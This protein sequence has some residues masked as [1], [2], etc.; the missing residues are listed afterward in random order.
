MAQVFKESV[1]RS[2]GADCTEVVIQHVCD[3]CVKANLDFSEPEFCPIQVEYGFSGEHPSIV[4]EGG[5]GG[6]RVWCVDKECGL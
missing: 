5:K 1:A 2:L 6:I 3:G 4:F